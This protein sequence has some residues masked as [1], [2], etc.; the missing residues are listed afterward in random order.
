[1]RI[2]LP[3]FHYA[4]CVADLLCTI[5]NAPS[6]MQTAWKANAKTKLLGSVDPGVREM[7]PPTT[8]AIQISPIKRNRMPPVRKRIF[9]VS[10]I[11]T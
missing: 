2:A 10:S 7:T 3:C 1:M 4:V 5:K 9:I 6:A 11:S 8:Q